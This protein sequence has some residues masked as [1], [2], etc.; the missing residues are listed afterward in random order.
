MGCGASSDSQILPTS[1]QLMTECRNGASGAVTD[2]SGAIKPISGL[3]LCFLL[4]CRLY[5]SNNPKPDDTAKL[6]LCS[7]AI[8]T[9]SDIL[10]FKSQHTQTD[11]QVLTDEEYEAMVEALN[12]EMVKVE[13]ECQQKTE[14][15]RDPE[16]EADEEVLLHSRKWKSFIKHHK[17]ESDNGKRCHNIAIQA[18]KRKFTNS[19]QTKLGSIDH[20][21][22]DKNDML[23]T[24]TSNMF[25][26]Q[27]ELLSKTLSQ[28]ISKP[29][30][31]VNI[32]QQLTTLLTSF[33]EDEDMDNF[34][35]DC[36]SEPSKRV[37]TIQ[38]TLKSFDEDSSEALVPEVNE[39]IQPTTRTSPDSASSTVVSKISNDTGKTKL[40]YHMG[41]MKQQRFNTRL[42]LFL[43]DIRTKNELTSKEC[44]DH[45]SLFVNKQFL[46]HR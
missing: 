25:L 20:Q 6:L 15:G 27:N 5:G 10:G 14:N 30:S 9:E 40:K 2:N 42:K 46:L 17:S 38:Q 41:V 31:L 36:L 39:S 33:E 13:K 26:D 24:K 7:V 28:V 12:E 23:F 43:D 19:T 32:D 21:F 8:Q 37:D 35:E 22:V 16:D 18:T 3:K 44:I 34:G 4:P 45:R 11:F 1:A 29:S